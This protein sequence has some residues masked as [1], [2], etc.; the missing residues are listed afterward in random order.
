MGWGGVKRLRELG[1]FLEEI[2]PRRAHL[3]HSGVLYISA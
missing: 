2:R 1:A 3:Y